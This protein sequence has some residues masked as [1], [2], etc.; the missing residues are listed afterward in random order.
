VVEPTHLK[1][2]IVKVEDISPGKV[3]NKTHLKP[4]PSHAFNGQLN[5]KKKKKG[6]R[7]WVL[8]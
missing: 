7:L 1:N 6:P 2:M 8:E 5:R 3:E 4:P